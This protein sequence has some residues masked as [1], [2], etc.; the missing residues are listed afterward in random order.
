MLHMQYPVLMFKERTVTHI[1]VAVSQKN[2]RG[3]I[4]VTS[5]GLALKIWV[6]WAS[7]LTGVMSISSYLES[8]VQNNFLTA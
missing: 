3:Q 6:T 4:W 8:Q 7:C 1:N 2:L 5:W